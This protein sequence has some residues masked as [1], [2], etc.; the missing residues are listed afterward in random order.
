[1]NKEKREYSFHYFSNEDQEFSSEHGVPAKYSIDHSVE[2]AGTT[3]WMQV[4]KEF[5]T[6]LSATYGYDVSSEISAKHKPLRDY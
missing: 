3:T 4:L 6:F 1:M 5:A 2:F